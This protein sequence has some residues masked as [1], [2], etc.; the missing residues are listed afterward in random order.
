[1]HAKGKPE[2]PVKQ[3][4]GAS[5]IIIF[6]KYMKLHIHELHIHTYTVSVFM[7]VMYLR[8]R[9]YIISTLMTLG[10][11]LVLEGKTRDTVL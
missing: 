6:F 2:K 1:M 4:V 3:N 8:Y 11:F 5:E 10:Y 9:R 7:L